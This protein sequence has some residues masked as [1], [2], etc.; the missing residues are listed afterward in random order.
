MR[1]YR[2]MSDNPARTLVAPINQP[3]EAEVL[4]A[5]EQLLR[6]LRS[7]SDGDV[8]SSDRLTFLRCIRTAGGLKIVDIGL[9]LRSGSLSEPERWEESKQW[10][11]V[12]GKVLANKPNPLPRPGQSARLEESVVPSKHFDPGNIPL[13]TGTEPS[14]G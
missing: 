1:L 10:W 6:A 9:G 12:T 13:R 4:N 8:K 3:D 7:A 2:S 14:L 11:E 5:P